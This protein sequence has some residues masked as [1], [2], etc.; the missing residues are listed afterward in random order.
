[1]MKKV[2][3]TIFACLAITGCGNMTKGKAAAQS[4]VTAFHKLFNDQDF[5][6]MVDSAD[7]KM[8]KVTSK[9]QLTDLYSAIRRKLGKV[10][11]SKSVR[12]NVRTFNTMTTVVVVQNTTFEK[13]KGMET[14]TF[15][16]KKEKASLLGYNINSQ[17]L[18]M[19]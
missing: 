16:I 18:I 4:Q 7:P 12:W 19:K 6:T 8:L 5:K 15:R 10:T 13:G 2:I 17:D 9:S 14:F 1:M 11:A 3:L